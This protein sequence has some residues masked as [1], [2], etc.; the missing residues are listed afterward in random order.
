MNPFVKEDAAERQL[1]RDAN[2][3]RQQSFLVA[4]ENAERK[5]P[6]KQD[7]GDENRSQISI[8]DAQPAFPSTNRGR[9]RERRRDQRFGSGLSHAGSLT[10][11]NW[12][13]TGLS[14]VCTLP[15][16]QRITAFSICGYFP[17]PKCS[18]R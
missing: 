6:G 2:H 11:C 9:R 5:M 13:P 16:G 14:I 3:D 12:S 8:F 7:A 1:S 4:L 15:D 10:L 18:R 17:S